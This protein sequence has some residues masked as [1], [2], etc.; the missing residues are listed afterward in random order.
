MGSEIPKGAKYLGIQRVWDCRSSWTNFLQRIYTKPFT[1]EQGRCLFTFAWPETLINAHHLRVLDEL[2]NRSL[3][4][5]GTEHLPFKRFASN[6]VYYYLKGNAFFLFETF[7]QDIDSPIILFTGYPTTFRLRRL[8]ITGKIARTA[9]WT[10]L[11]ITAMAQRTLQFLNLWKR[12]L[13]IPLIG[14]CSSCPGRSSSIK[15]IH[16][17]TF[18][19]RDK[20]VIGACN[21]WPPPLIWLSDFHG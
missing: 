2:V 8:D 15:S 1:Y 11:K 12:S 5:F 9:A 21:Y 10:V 7:K 3:R 19:D 17:D 4:E 13:A 20:S 14:D 16:I 18:P 6:S